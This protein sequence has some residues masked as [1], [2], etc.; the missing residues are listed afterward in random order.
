[1]TK[2]RT[3]LSLSALERLRLR[4]QASIEDVPVAAVVRQAVDQ[5]LTVEG[6]SPTPVKQMATKVTTLTV[7]PRG[8]LT[9]PAALVHAVG[10][11]PDDAVTVDAVAGD[12]LVLTPT[13]EADR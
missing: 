6:A 13:R 5:Y 12:Q 11:V 3:L 7:S 8:T 1:M 2:V 10:L 9:I 4:R